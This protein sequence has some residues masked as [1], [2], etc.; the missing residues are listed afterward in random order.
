MTVLAGGWGESYLIV[1]F[2]SRQG[3][4]FFKYS[5]LSVYVLISCICSQFIILQL[6]HTHTHTHTHTLTHEHTQKEGDN[7]I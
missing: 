5:V 7:V 3:H 2:C 4:F 1:L 6:E